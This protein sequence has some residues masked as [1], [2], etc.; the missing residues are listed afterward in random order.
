M[1]AQRQGFYKPVDATSAKPALPLYRFDLVSMPRMVMKCCISS[2]RPLRE[3]SIGIL[4]RPRVFFR[5]NSETAPR[6]PSSGCTRSLTICR[7]HN[8]IADPGA[9]AV[10]DYE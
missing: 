4:S 2:G 7:R 10:Q 5:E 6:Y 3:R 8:S 1:L 9:E